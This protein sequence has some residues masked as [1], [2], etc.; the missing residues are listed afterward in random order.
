LSHESLPV[1]YYLNELISG[2]ALCV[3]WIIRW[4]F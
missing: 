4:P 2:A 3:R 1:L